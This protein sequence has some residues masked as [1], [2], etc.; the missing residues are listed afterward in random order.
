MK[1]KQYKY[2]KNRFNFETREFKRL[3][4]NY[5][6]KQKFETNSKKMIIVKFNVFLK[7]K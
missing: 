1:K 2:K 7:T 5:K 4:K 6:M 3:M